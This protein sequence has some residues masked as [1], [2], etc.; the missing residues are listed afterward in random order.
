MDNINSKVKN[1]FL[2]IYKNILFDMFIGLTLLYYFVEYK[3]L[4]ITL[5]QDIN[6]QPGRGWPRQEHLVGHRLLSEPLFMGGAYS[7]SID[8]YNLGPIPY[9]YPVGL[10]WLTNKVLPKFEISP[11]YITTNVL[12]FITLAIIIYIIYLAGKLYN[13]KGVYIFIF[14]FVASL[15][16]NKGEHYYTGIPSYM[17]PGSVQFYSI[18]TILLFLASFKT[19][20]RKYLYLLIFFSGI[21]LQNY[22][23]TIIYC[24]ILLLYGLYGLKK[25]NDKSKLTYLI[26]TISLLPWLQI[27]YRIATG[28][29]EINDTI[30]FIIY[31]NS[32]ENTTNYSIS[33]TSLIN[34]NPFN[35]LLANLIDKNALPN[36]LSIIFGIYFI[37]LP[38][39]NYLL[40]KKEIINNN[41]KS[42]VLKI[43]TLL[44]TI[45]III[46]IYASN[47]GQQFNHLAGY[48]YLFT[49]LIIYKILHNFKGKTT[50]FILSFM[51]ALATF[52]NTSQVY[53]KAQ[54]NNILSNSVKAE[55]R[56]QPI[57]IIQYDF[58]NRMEAA[59]TD[60]VYELLS[61]NIDLCLI[62]PNKSTI[63]KLYGKNNS[64]VDSMLRNNKF[65]KHLFCDFSQVNEKE[66][67]SV[68][69]IEDPSSS[70]PFKLK[71]ASLV[72]R[73]SNEFTNRCSPEYYR[74]LEINLQ[75][76]NECMYFR[77][78]NTLINLS[79]YLQDNTKIVDPFTSQNKIIESSIL[80]GKTN[81]GNG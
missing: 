14:I 46:N 79:V 66:R 49:F 61:E 54:E 76:K 10:G 17:N 53:N 73:M 37:S 11:F 80:S 70:L 8:N 56:K 67:R 2:Y 24:V 41:N 78:G 72:A 7:G 19:N 13:R 9:N 62:E 39:L 51:I 6:L 25:S 81:W 75:S 26:A 4:S 71:N 15:T 23:A 32:W 57:K 18:L 20:S 52:S 68:Y 64:H 36:S 29:A 27:I 44:F 59:Y 21:L 30:K 47:E 45:D 5:F 65:V 28:F 60:F 58:Y 31:R 3:I 1:K 69:L 43:I 33:L 55:L 48:S 22:I 50:L 77:P 16:I 63:N 40:L 74:K 12:Y 42:R 34:Q 35:N 38:L